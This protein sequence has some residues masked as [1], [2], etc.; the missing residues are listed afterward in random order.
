C[1]TKLC[2][3]EGENHELSRSG[4]PKQRLQRLVEMLDWFSVYIKKD[5]IGQ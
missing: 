2:L 3:F 5:N 4:R 1:P